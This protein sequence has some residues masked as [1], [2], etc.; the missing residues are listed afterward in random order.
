[1]LTAQIQVQIV[2]TSPVKVL[3]VNKS[4][5]FDETNTRPISTINESMSNIPTLEELSPSFSFFANSPSD[6]LLSEYVSNTYQS[7]QDM[8]SPDKCGSAIMPLNNIYP[9]RKETNLST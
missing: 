8:F 1:M 4:L 2:T 6:H 3:I 5:I 7:D 9:Q